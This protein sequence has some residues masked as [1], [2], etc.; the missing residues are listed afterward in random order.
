MNR[1]S[2]I[3]SQYTAVCGGLHLCSGVM[4]RRESSFAASMLSRAAPY[5]SRQPG[6]LGSVRWYWMGPMPLMAM[7][8]G[9]V[10]VFFTP[11]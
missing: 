5:T 10:S 6:L 1:V 2:T 3:F 11:S 7:I 8:A 4:L 9:S